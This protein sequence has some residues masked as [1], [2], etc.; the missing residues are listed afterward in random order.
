MNSHKRKKTVEVERGDQAPGGGGGGYIFKP[1][2]G[3]IHP[4][5]NATTPTEPIASI[6]DRRWGASIPP[7]I[8]PPRSPFVFR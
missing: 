4:Q 7:S 3:P 1:S 6:D 2:S 5:H 8:S